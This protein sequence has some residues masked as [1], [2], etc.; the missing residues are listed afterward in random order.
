MQENRPSINA[1]S[2]SEVLLF[3]S[4]RLFK[5]MFKAHLVTLENLAEEHDIA[6]N[7]LIDA[8]PEEYRNFVALADYY[9]ETKQQIL[10]KQTLGHGNDM[11]REFE[12]LVDNFN[13]EYKQK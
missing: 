3:Q 12:R 7:K 2:A 5:N 11:M 13:I 9:T 1:P 8:L 4:V 6:L 10:R